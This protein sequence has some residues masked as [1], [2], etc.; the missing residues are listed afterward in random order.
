MLE[1]YNT[2]GKKREKLAVEGD[3]IKIYVCGPTVYSY[4]HIGNGRPL[5]L[6][7]TL[8]KYLKYR[9]YRVKYAQNFTDIDDKI[10]KG[11]REEKKDIYTFAQKYIDEYY[12]DA[13][14]L[15]IDRADFAPRATEHID[16]M[17]NMIAKLIDKGFAYKGRDGIYFS[18]KKKANYGALSNQK[19]EELNS[20]GDDLDFALWKFEEDKSISWPSPWGRGRPGWHIEC[21]AMIESIFGTTIEIHGGGQDLCFPHHENEI[22]Q[23]EACFDRALAKIWIHNGLLKLKDGKMSKSKGNIVKIR[24][25][26]KKFSGNAV[27]L[28]MLSAHHRKPIDFSLDKLAG[29][30]N[31][32]N[33]IAKFIS[34]SQKHLSNPQ[35]QKIESVDL[36]IY[37]ERVVEKFN[38][39]MDKDLNTPGALASIFETIR[40]VNPFIAKATSSSL[41]S[42]ITL[43]ENL[44]GVLG[45]DLSKNKEEESTV[46]S[47]HTGA[48]IRRRDEAR[49]NKDWELADN[50]RRELESL[51]IKLEDGEKGTNWK[52]KN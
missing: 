4:I 10:V 42:L 1:L 21:S 51:N 47:D 39:E 8:R 43:L 26:H 19:V 22:A 13:Q 44:L 23:S 27:R 5:I 3:E 24:D 41:K 40:D 31:S 7:D 28:F 9:G 33:K 46:S 32:L 18:V 2:L 6:F 20:E 15:N 49:K 48:L 14:Y 34:D 11:S 38:S 29:F 50:I 36:K 16:D 12:V 25:L 17:K 45:I 30:E 35:E 37:E 52:I